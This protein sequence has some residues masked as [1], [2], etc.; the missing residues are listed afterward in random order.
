MESCE[1]NLLS[2]SV[3]GTWCTAVQ[4]RKEGRKY[5]PKTRSHEELRIMAI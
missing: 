5:C 3:C 4:R 1:K 2:A